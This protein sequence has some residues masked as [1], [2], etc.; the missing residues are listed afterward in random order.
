[1]ANCDKI[2]VGFQILGPFPH[3]LF[4]RQPVMIAEFRC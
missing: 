4:Q 1:M 3:G 2:K